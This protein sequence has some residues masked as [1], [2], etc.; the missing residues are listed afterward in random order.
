MPSFVVTADDRAWFGRCH[1]AWDLGAR[2]RRRPGAGRRRAG[3]SRRWPGPWPRPSPSTTSPACGPGTGRSSTRSSS[4]P[5]S[6]P[7]ALRRAV[8]CSEAFRTLGRPA[9]TASPR[10]GRGRHRRAGPR[11][12]AARHAPG[13][14]GG[15]R[16][17]S[18]SDR[19]RLVLVDDEDE[20]CWLGDHRVVDDF[21]D[22]RRAGARRAAADGVLGVGQIE[23]ALAGRR[24]PPHRAA[25][26]RPSCRRTV[27]RLHHDARSATP[28][29]ASAR[30]CGRCS[31]RRSRWTPPRRGRT[32][33][34]AP[35]RAPV[36]RDEPGR[37][38]RRRC[39]PTRYRAAAAGPARGGPARRDE[40]GHGPRRR[41]AALRTVAERRRDA[42]AG[43][44]WRAAAM[45][46][47]P[48]LMPPSLGGTC[49][50]TRT[51][52]AGA[53]R[54]RSRRPR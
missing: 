36:P 20:R 34:G 18:T 2:G 4:R 33:R 53:R 14:G 16:G 9:S 27:V 25:A 32:A 23:L 11:S 35:F 50:C 6:A 3:P 46:A 51:V 37:G 5:T 42:A 28:R 44:A 1:R 26:R 10:P 17:P 7:A 31:T 38:R 48:M 12:R 15:R 19:I 13:H 39:W 21:A 45:A 41:T 30:P 49:W 29:P 47:W 52:K 8:A 24:R 40:L 54:A 22:P 43:S